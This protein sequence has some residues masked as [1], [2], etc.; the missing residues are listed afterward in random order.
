MVDLREFQKNKR[1]KGKQNCNGR[2]STCAGRNMKRS[3]RKTGVIEELIRGR[4]GVVRGAKVRRAGSKNETINRSVL[5]LI[6]L[7]IACSGYVKKEGKV[8]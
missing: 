4:D 2:F 8:E 1:S 3:C 6:P 7:G 5:K